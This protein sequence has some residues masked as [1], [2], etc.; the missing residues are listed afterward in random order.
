MDTLTHA[1]S[2]AL[3]AR[4]TA[5]KESAP[6]ALPTGRRV[7]VGFFAAAFPDAD[8]LFSYIS[9]L[10][11]LYHH[12]GITHSIPLLPLWTVALAWVF[13]YIWRNKPGWRAYA[14]V[15]ALG[16]GAHIA[17]D[18][19][20]SFG[21]IIFAPFSDW[22][23]ALSTTFIIDLWFTGI[24][25][26][27]LLAAALWRRSRVP[28]ALGLVVLGAYVGM[29]YLV[30]QRALEFGA[31]HARAA[32]LGGANITAQPRPVSPFNWMVVVDEGSR[33]HYSLVNFVRREAP[34]LPPDAG[35]VARLSAPYLPP[36]QAVWVTL[37]R[38][39]TAAAEAAVAK[40]AFD[41]PGFAFFRWF[42]RYPV[43]YRVDQGNPE[44]CVWFQDLRF[45][46]PGRSRWPFRYGMCREPGGPWRPYE[47]DNGA[48]FAVY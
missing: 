16:I 41:S 22:R 42:A 25:F 30:Q 47:L 6:G 29:Q 20:T 35:F 44:T 40:D 3:I 13:A 23:A 34:A 14:G 27:A 32:G 28:A 24:I 8:V 33:Y 9:P 10:A 12:R 43:L 21:T 2:G 39:G 7:L 18:L 45:F 26:A 37:D 46:T 5:P 19:I 11:Y 1:L 36:E 38:F 31:E 48:R 4:A 17:G 15:A